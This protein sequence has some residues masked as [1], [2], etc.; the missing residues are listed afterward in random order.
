MSEG[1]LSNFIVLSFALT[2]RFILKQLG[3]SLSIFSEAGV[4]ATQIFLEILKRELILCCRFFIF[5][6]LP[7][8]VKLPWQPQ[9]Q[10]YNDGSDNFFLI[11]MFF[12]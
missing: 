3:Y 1:D 10:N 7:M 8:P 6:S 9:P 4:D 5:Q 11:W 12:F 2:S